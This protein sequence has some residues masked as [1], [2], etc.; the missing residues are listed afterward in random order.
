MPDAVPLKGV[1][2]LVTRP[3]AQAGSLC[4]LIEQQ[5]GAA[6][7]F[8]VLEIIQPADPQAVTRFSERLDAFDW[9]F[10]VSANA[11][12]MAL[13]VILEKRSWPESVSIAVIGKRS[14][15]ELQRFGMVADL[16]PESRF[17]SEGLLALPQMQQLDGQRCV[18]FRGGGGRDLL[19]NTLRER[20]ARVEYVEAYRRIR[21]RVDSNTLLTQWRAGMI[22]IVLVNSVESLQNLT[23]MLGSAG[24]SLLLST[25][26]LVV[27]ERLAAIARQLGFKKPPLVANNATDAAVLDALL[28][29]R[30]LQEIQ[31]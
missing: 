16:V 20:G 10:F 17:D 15:E 14:A 9:A 2:I 24:K 21:P 31:E 5:G 11:V 23:E 22:D 26:L 4:E 25:P 7:R 27:S 29:W 30:S 12:N 6:F 3:A 19:A 18:I 8:P 13:P 28:A 1:G